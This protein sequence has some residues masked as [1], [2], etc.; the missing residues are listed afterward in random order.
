MLLVVVRGLVEVGDG[1]VVEA[2]LLEICVVVVL[3]LVAE[4]RVVDQDGAQDVHLVFLRPGS[5]C[6]VVDRG[7]VE[8]LGER[9]RSSARSL[10]SL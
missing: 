6:S 4:L 2:E 5:P 3:G 1:L 8:R 9:P 10:N 7:V